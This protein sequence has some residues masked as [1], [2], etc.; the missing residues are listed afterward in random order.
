MR[1]DFEDLSPFRDQMAFLQEAL[2]EYP[3]NLISYRDLTGA[4][5]C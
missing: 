2:I 1:T 4:L 5:S 3:P